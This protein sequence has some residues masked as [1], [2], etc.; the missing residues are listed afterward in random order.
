MLILTLLPK[1]CCQ[2]QI[3]SLN[4]RKLFW[5]LL[6]FT[7][8]Y[9]NCHELYSSILLATIST[10]NIQ[11]SLVFRNQFAFHT[12]LKKRIY[13]FSTSKRSSEMHQLFLSVW[14]K[15]KVLLKMLINFIKAIVNL[16]SYEED[17]LFVHQSTNHTIP[18]KKNYFLS[19][20]FLFSNTFSAF[21]LL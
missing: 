15:N 17:T 10:K 2:V 14:L 13:P 7:S 8:F 3:C 1:S 20:D 5:C 11:N 6:D 12:M 18:C 4:W 19:I 16:F 21:L 9:L